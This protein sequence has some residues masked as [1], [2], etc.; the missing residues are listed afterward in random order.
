MRERVLSPAP[1][2]TTSWVSAQVDRRPSN[3]IGFEWFSGGAIML[4]EE[5]SKF[6]GKAGDV[7]VFEVEKEPIR[8]FADAVGDPNPLYRDEEYAR[9]SRYGSIIAP[10][11]FISSPWFSQPKSGTPSSSAR[12]EL[13]D[14]LRKAGYTNPA[15]VDAGIEYEFFCPVRAGDT[16]AFTSTIKDV[17][18]R[19]GKTGKMAFITTETNYTNQNGD[20]VAT[21]RG[22]AIQR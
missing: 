2:Y 17:V 5:V 20:L 8:R 3:I 15:A 6:I 19:E 13:R 21:A 12:E 7:R 22:T 4:P 14:A 1:S 10:P 11:G 9:S 16:I 18:E